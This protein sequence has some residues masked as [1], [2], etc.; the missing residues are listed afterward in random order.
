VPDAFDYLGPQAEVFFRKVSQTARVLE[1]TISVNA[2][3]A[4][5]LFADCVLQ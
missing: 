5:Q 4:L 3:V 1:S 2:V